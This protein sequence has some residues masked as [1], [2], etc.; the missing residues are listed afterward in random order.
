M[1]KLQVG[2]EEEKRVYW[3]RK[4]LGNYAKRLAG[5]IKWGKRWWTRLP[6][7]PA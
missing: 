7:E 5:R 4:K 1:S 3:E 2:T 6:H